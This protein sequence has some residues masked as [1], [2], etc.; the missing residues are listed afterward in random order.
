MLNVLREKRIMFPFIC[1]VVALVIGS[2]FCVVLV[3]REAQAKQALEGS[4]RRM[5]LL[6]RKGMHMPTD[7]R[8]S[9]LS[10][11]NTSL[12]NQVVTIMDAMRE[13]GGFRDMYKEHKT[14]LEFRELI[15]QTRTR[16]SR[17]DIGFDAYVVQVPKPELLPTLKRQLA[18]VAKLLT[19]AEAAKIENVSMISRQKPKVISANETDL[20]KEYPILLTLQCRTKTLVPFLYRVCTSEALLIIRGI[21]VTSQVGSLLHVI[22]KVSYVEMVT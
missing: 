17:E 6:L 2:V 5:K 19:L 8:I 15:G 22:L 11:F 13:K 18:M 1:C 9:A 7:R 10:E 14:P 20:F 4:V 21:K 16:F 3:V 12:R